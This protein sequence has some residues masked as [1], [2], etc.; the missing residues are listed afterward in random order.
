MRSTGRART[1]AFESLV[2]AAVLGGCAAPQTRAV[3]AR[4][5]AADYLNPVEPAPVAT[6]NGSNG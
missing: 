2:V 1:A 4:A 3:H 6:I 5:F